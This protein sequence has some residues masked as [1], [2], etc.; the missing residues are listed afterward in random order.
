MSQFQNPGGSNGI[1]PLDLTNLPFQPRRVIKWG[2]LI[3]GLV[4]SLVLL[5]WVRGI[6]TDLLW[7]DQ[8][9]FTEVFRTI[10]FTRIWLFFTG[11]LI[12]AIFLGMNIFFT[13][14]IGRGPQVSVISQDSLH[15]FRPLLLI[16]AILGTVI[17][18][19]IFGV[20]LSG[21]WE[22]VLNFFN[23]SS[24]GIDDP[25]F[26]RDIAFYTFTMPFLQLIQGLLL[27][28]LAITTILTAGLY[29][30]HFNLRGAVFTLTPKVFLHISILGTLILFT[31]GFGYY[32][33][34]FNLVFSDRG[35]VV[36][37]SYTDVTAGL[38]SLRVLIGTMVI[39]GLLFL[40]NGLIWR[41]LRLV[42]GVLG[43]WVIIAVGLG[44]LYP[45]LIQRVQVNPNELRRET[46]YIE[47]NIEFTRAAFAL[48]RIAEEDYPLAAEGEVTLPLVNANLDTVN[49]IRLWDHRPF[50]SLLN[51]IQFFRLYYNFP[52]ADVDRYEFTSDDGKTELRQV[53]LGTRELDSLNL[54]EQ[55]QS[56]VNRKLQFTHGYGAVMSP[57]TEFT[58]EGRPLFFLKDLPPTGDI[59]LDRPQVYYGETNENFVIVNSKQLELDYEPE[60]GPPIYAA[61]DGKGG[62]PL[63]GIIRRISYAMQFAD[64]NI[65]VSGEITPESRI[66]YRRNIQER[67]EKVAPFLSLDSDPY[68]V[69]SDG[70]L[71]WIQ[72]AYTKTDHYPYST[73]E[74]TQFGKL[75]YIRNSVKVVINAYSGELQFYVT[76][77][78]DP[79][80]VT[81]QKIFPT[82]FKS[83]QEMPQGLKDHI[84]YPQDLFSIQAEQYLTYH[85]TD[86]N[87]FFN[88]ADQWSVPQEF[89]RGTFQP[90]EPYFLNMRLPGE[91]KE[92]FVLLLPFT[93]A[94]RENMVGWLAARSDGTSYGKLLAFAFPK[95][96][97][98]FGP[99]QV[100]ARISTDEK[101]KEFF[102]LRC[103]GEA[104]CIRGNLLVIPMEGTEG[105]NQILYA[106][107]LY[108]QATGLAFPELK[109]VILADT[110]RV[111]MEATLEEA[112][113]AL[114]SG[115]TT[116]SD[117]AQDTAGIKVDTPSFIS[118]E[119]TTETQDT[120]VHALTF[121]EEVA[122]I[123][124]AVESVAEQFN[125]LQESLERLLLHDEKR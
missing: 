85:M 32:L 79:L 121:E 39:G 47:R 58:A 46:P 72:D 97:T 21:H 6:Y 111:V 107:P 101:I 66:Q 17:G 100:E 37:A 16:G 23:S 109:Q 119:Q 13:Y 118:E 103:T 49:N 5:N 40:L 48:D 122:L 94:E 87:E 115:R 102:A 51:Q 82:L 106:E 54:P 112:I 31:M 12:F 110:S 69:I 77:P 26:G 59:S 73:P 124:E 113:A 95:G 45:A 64:I 8:L 14:K 92:E 105:N 34:V 50:L 60:V 2:G 4:A 67:V 88:K 74:T 71:F 27:V 83:L 43:L 75:N 36:G 1:P 24:F 7:F 84:R 28:I 117:T 20:F 56:W 52:N 90:M 38:L 123:S 86:T 70:E 3:F 63:S 11:V 89:F 19:I 55:A 25:Q 96:V 114:T 9:E 120:S 57:V 41:R 116:A 78:E 15:I 30:A 35:A 22:I 42:V 44:G 99:S 80:I 91:E 10:L 29:F 93:P 65:L 18:S 98:Y 53:M 81:T 76:E 104:S 68:I 33:S 62:I 125:I 108:L 61:Y